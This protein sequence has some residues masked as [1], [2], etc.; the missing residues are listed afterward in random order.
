MTD[1][2][3]LTLDAGTSSVRTLL[4][5]ENARQIPGFGSQLQYH[6]TTTADGGVEIDADQLCALAIR[7]LSDIHKQLEA[8]GRRPSAFGFSSFWHNMLGVDAGGHPATAILHPFDTRSNNAAKELA[9]RT[10]GA[11]IHARTG[12]VLH[13]SYWPAKL[14]WLS[15]TQADAF[16]ASKR[17]MSFG[18]YFFG[19]LFGKAVASTSMVSG[20]GLW[21]QND[22]DYDA[23]TLSLLPVVTPGQLC[24]VDELDQPLT[25]LC[26]EYASQW[27]TVRRHPLVP[28]DRRRGLRQHR[29]RLH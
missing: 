14:L 28:R 1:L 24:P 11:A 25:R 20:S 15:E 9:G 27:P 29:Q 5:D 3:I 6:E 22:N 8:A 23:E 26:A 18:E 7:C 2:S 10:D 16:R 4:Y 13:P 19:K 21:N 17:W 12:C